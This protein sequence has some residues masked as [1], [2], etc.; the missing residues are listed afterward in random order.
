MQVYGCLEFSAPWSIDQKEGATMVAGRV[1]SMGVPMRLWT[2]AA[3]SRLGGR[4]T[5]ERRY[6]LVPFM[7]CLEHLSSSLRD[8]WG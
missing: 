4:W 5:E 6:F 2:H 3:L 1:P 8:T 7:P